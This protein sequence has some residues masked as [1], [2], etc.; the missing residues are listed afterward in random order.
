MLEFIKKIYTNIVRI[1]LFSIFLW[2]C[3]FILYFIVGYFQIPSS[4]KRTFKDDIGCCEVVLNTSFRI[5][6]YWNDI[7]DRRA[8]VNYILDVKIKDEYTYTE[9]KLEDYLILSFLDKDGFKLFKNQIKLN[10]LTRVVD[11]NNTEAFS[12][13]NILDRCDFDKYKKIDKVIISYNLPNIKQSS[14]IMKKSEILKLTEEE[15]I[16]LVNKL[17]E[18]NLKISIIDDTIPNTSIP[19]GWEIVKPDSKINEKNITWDKK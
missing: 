5:D 18:N 11:D 12:D 8:N 10:S 4:E 6:S 7:V 2:F 15:K 19:E 3:G 17:K 1:S 16:K 9:S 14:I 13:S